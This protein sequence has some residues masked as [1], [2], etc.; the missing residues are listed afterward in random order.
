MCF[1]INRSKIAHYGGFGKIISGKGQDVSGFTLSI[2]PKT[3]P[4][5]KTRAHVFI[6]TRSGSKVPH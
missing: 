1:C 4:D 5:T 3:V 6:Y 2:F